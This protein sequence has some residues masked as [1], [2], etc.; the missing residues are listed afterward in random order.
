MFEKVWLRPTFV[1]RLT[2][3]VD[4]LSDIYLRFFFLSHHNLSLLKYAHTLSVTFLTGL[5]QHV[6]YLELSN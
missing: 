3:C 4:T 6:T 5:L 1:D 2:G